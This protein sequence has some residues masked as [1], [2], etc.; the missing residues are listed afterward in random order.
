M[1]IRVKHTGDDTYQE[2][3]VD[4]IELQGPVVIDNDDLGGFTLKTI[5]DNN[6]ETDAE[7]QGGPHEYAN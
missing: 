5:P 2:Y 4:A 6:G 7:M 1:R 3:D